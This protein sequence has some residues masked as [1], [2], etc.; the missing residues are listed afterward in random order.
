MAP[1]G[2][3]Y[4]AKYCNNLA[5]YHWNRC[6]ETAC[7]DDF[8][9]A[10]Y[11]Y[12]SSLHHANSDMA[13]RISAGKALFESFADV[14]EWQKALEAANTTFSLLP[15]LAPRS[16]GSADRQ[17]LLGRITGLSCDVAA[18][19][20]QAGGCA[21]AALSI[22]EQ[23]RGILASSIEQ[24]HVSLLELRESHPELA[25]QFMQVRDELDAPIHY[26]DA[27]VSQAKA[28]RRSEASQNFDNLLNEIRE[29]PGF[30]DFLGAASENE[31]C[32]AARFG[33]II[34]I[35]LSRYRSDAILVEQHQIRSLA[36]PDLTSDI[37]DKREKEGYLRGYETLEWLW[38]VATGPIL[39]ALGLTG[40]PLDDNW[41]RVWDPAQSG[42]VLEDGTLTVAALLEKNLREYSP[43]LAY[44][45]A[46]G[47]GQ[48][49]GEHFF[50]ES[51]HLISACQLAGFRHAIGTL[52]EVND[53][54][55][56]DVTRL[57]YESMGEEG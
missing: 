40:P 5:D 30:S 41:P 2:D 7:L 25:E 13:T 9:K 38:K 20:L 35:N 22:L 8:E 52:R 50:D 21:A 12:E 4:R 28:V 42:L 46:C 16:L 33:P 26:S 6:S 54:S 43:F 18:V 45:S 37:L 39:D 55:C 53:E 36:L 17:R 31:M 11:Y 29:R 57:T 49:G 14:S 51:L 44:L 48:T 32:A 24:T 27:S 15:K 19:T 47:T 1:Q 56:M 3:P 34:V 10:V 23:G